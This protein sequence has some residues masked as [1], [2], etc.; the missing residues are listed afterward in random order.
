MEDT[1][2]RLVTL[3]ASGIS[4]LVQELVCVVRYRMAYLMEV[5]CRREQ[6]VK[7]SFF[8]GIEGTEGASSSQSSES[9]AVRGGYYAIVWERVH[10]IWRLTFDLG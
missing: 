4:S 1:A 9:P 7:E 5:A 6:N 3:R 2:C 10:K 8:S